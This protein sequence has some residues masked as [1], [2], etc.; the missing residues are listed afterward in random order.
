MLCSVG[1]GRGLKQMPGHLE[2]TA[3]HTHLQH[4]LNVWIRANG[5]RIQRAVHTCKTRGWIASIQAR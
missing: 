5:I 4:G 2:G 1:G 3:L